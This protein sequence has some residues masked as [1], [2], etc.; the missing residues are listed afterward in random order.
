MICYRT[1]LVLALPSELRHSIQK[2]REQA[3][4]KRQQRRRTALGPGPDP[5]SLFDRAP[6]DTEWDTFA[7]LSFQS[8]ELCVVCPRRQVP[9]KVR[10]LVLQAVLG[11]VSNGCSR[12]GVESKGQRKDDL[13]EESDGGGKVKSA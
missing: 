12:D 13:E 7:H 3:E 5:G 6:T 4:Q 8:S 1:P 2:E 11:S 10:G 9:T